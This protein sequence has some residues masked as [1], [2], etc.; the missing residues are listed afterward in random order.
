M[1]PHNLRTSESGSNNEEE[2]LTGYS[3]YIRDGDRLYR[4]CLARCSSYGWPHEATWPEDSI[5]ETNKREF[6][7]GPFLEMIFSRLLRLPYQV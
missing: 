6:Y 1:V 2:E 4:A 5:S 7:E 3:Q